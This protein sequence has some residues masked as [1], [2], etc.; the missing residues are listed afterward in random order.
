MV[1]V[2]QTNNLKRKSSRWQNLPPYG[3][4]NGSEFES[5][6][7]KCSLLL[8]L[9]DL[10]ANQKKWSQFVNMLENSPGIIDESSIA[11][12]LL[13]AMKGVSKVDQ[14]YISPDAPDTK[15]RRIDILGNSAAGEI[16]AEYNELIRLARTLFSG[17]LT[18]VLGDLYRRNLGRDFGDKNYTLE[19]IM[20]MA[21]SWG[22]VRY[23]FMNHLLRD[24]PNM[25]PTYSM[26][27]RRIK[28][29]A[30]NEMI[31][32][33]NVV[34]D[35][36][37]VEFRMD[38]GIG[39]TAQDRAIFE[40]TYLLT[41]E[42]GREIVSNSGQNTGLRIG[43]PPVFAYIAGFINGIVNWRVRVLEAS[44]KQTLAS[45]AYHQARGFTA[46]QAILDARHQPNHRGLASVDGPYANDLIPTI[47]SLLEEAR[48]QN[49]FLRETFNKLETTVSTMIQAVRTSP[50]NSVSP[51]LAQNAQFTTM[52]NA[53]PGP[54]TLIRPTGASIINVRRAPRSR[55]YK[56]RYQMQVRENIELVISA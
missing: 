15:K 55:S 36:K 34:A 6:S 37:L 4:E 44:R 29:D 28:G 52:L 5:D 42:E 24:D 47:K 40:Q 46:K 7:S 27:H 41:P 11:A 1:T 12:Q 30:A 8:F 32:E 54:F 13:E 33:S 9:R 35:S 21:R 31:H 51:E 19:E 20:H 39:Y 49:A 48:T 45:Q 43:L 22:E 50:M 26:G 25:G 3:E 2:P 14:D 38:K 10:E 16:L 17:E 18:D 56:P 23:R 53:F